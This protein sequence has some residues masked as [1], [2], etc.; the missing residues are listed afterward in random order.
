MA[1]VKR[2]EGEGEGEMEKEEG[3][4]RERE[5]ERSGQDEKVTPALIIDYV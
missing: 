5:G 4:G 1:G 3:K 2:P